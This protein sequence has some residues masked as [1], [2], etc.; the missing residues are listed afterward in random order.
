MFWELLPHAQDQTLFI[1]IF[2]HK[3]KNQLQ[4]EPQIQSTRAQQSDPGGNQEMMLIRGLSF[5]VTTKLLRVT[6]RHLNPQLKSK[7]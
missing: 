7:L 2:W 5:Q 4:K 6:I 1:Y 3:L